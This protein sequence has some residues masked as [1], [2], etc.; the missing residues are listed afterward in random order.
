MIY[1]ELTSTERGVYLIY[2]HFPR[3]KHSEMQHLN[4]LLIIANLSIS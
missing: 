2:T 3:I 4:W 1:M